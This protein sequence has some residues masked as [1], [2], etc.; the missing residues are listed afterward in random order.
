MSLRRDRIAGAMDFHRAARAVKVAA[1]PVPPSLVWI[2][3]TDQ[4]H[5][6]ATDHVG[7]AV[8]DLD[9][10]IGFYEAL[11]GVP[12]LMRKT[13]MSGYVGEIV[14]Y[15][16]VVWRA[17][18]SACPAG[19]SSSCSSTSRPTRAEVWTWSRTTRNAHSRLVTD[20]MEAT[21]ARLRAAGYDGFRSQ[22]PSSSPGATRGRACHLRDP[23]GTSI[24]L[25][26]EPP[27]G[28]DWSV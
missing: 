11:L 18:S 1:V 28:P 21:Y 4:G 5:F 3:M 22:N 14:G 20:D 24:E 10:S 12:L 9:R 2:D 27:G 15:P 25:M 7:Y 23:D 8:A 13:W 19:S 16:D 26:E 6:R 17:R